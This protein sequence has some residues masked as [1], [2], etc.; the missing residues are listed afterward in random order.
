[1]EQFMEILK[2]TLPSAVVLYGVYL[3]VKT[4][5]NKRY[6]ES[7]SLLKEKNHETILPLRLQAYERLTLFLERMAF[8]NLLVR[9]T[10]HTLTTEEFQHILINEIRMEFNHNVAQQIYMSD[11]AWDMIKQ[12]KEELISMVNST[13]KEVDPQASAMELSKRLVEK[14]IG[15]QHDFI[16]IAVRYLKKEVRELF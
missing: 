16:D 7:L 8:Q 11:E 15:A 12:A 2:M 9:L 4:F 5:L 14:A 3:T 13:A 6:E 10:D 1:M